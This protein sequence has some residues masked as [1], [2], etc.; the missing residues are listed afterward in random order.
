M[1]KIANCDLFCFVLLRFEPEIFKKPWSIIF[2]EMQN[3]KIKQPK[4]SES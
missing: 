3:V 2:I 4:N 1:A